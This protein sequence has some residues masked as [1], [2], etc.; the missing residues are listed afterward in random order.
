MRVVIE[1]VGGRL[2]LVEVVAMLTGGRL[3]LA[4]LA[5]D[6][7][8]LVAQLRDLLKRLFQRHC[9]SSSRNP[10]DPRVT[11]QPSASGAMLR[12][13]TTAKIGSHRLGH[14]AIVQ[15]VN[16]DDITPELVSRLVASQFPTWAHLPAWPVDLDGWDNATFRLGA[17]MSVRLPSAPQY[18]AGVDK[19][20]RWL[21]VLA[22]HLPLPVP[23]PLAKGSSGCG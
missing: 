18:E 9:L 13:R 3:L 2:H 1:A 23:Q 11:G 12:P 19:E 4:A 7:E 14:S 17:D 8:F 10:A 21:P 16:K 5:H 15:H 20:H 6:A 22:A